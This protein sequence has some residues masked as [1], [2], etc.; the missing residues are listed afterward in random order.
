MLGWRKFRGESVD[1]VGQALA[2]CLERVEGGESPEEALARYPALHEELEPLLTTALHARAVAPEQPDRAFR[3]RLRYRLEGAAQVSA[4]PS[5]LAFALWRARLVSAAITLLLLFLVAGGAVGVSARSLPDSPLYP[6]KRATEDAHLAL[7]PNLAQR[8][9]LRLNFAERRLL[10]AQA[11][12]ERKGV[13][14]EGGLLEMVGVTETVLEE[15]EV[16]ADPS[17]VEG[18]QRIPV[19]GGRQRAFLEHLAQE[20]PSRRARWLAEMLLHYTAGWNSRVEAVLE[21]VESGGP[22]HG[23]P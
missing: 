9:W 13:V 12:W 5:R 8:F 16:Y 18:L 21:E 1:P 3:A 19:L 17:M 2:D 4:R 10:E 23:Q 14:W 20:A 11:V 6:L 7:T 22:S 15:Y